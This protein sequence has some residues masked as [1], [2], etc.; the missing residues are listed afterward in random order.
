MGFT[1][2]DF[3]LK[4]AIAFSAIAFEIGQG[5]L[6]AAD[7]HDRENR[8]R[9]GHPPAPDIH[10]RQAVSLAARSQSAISSAVFALP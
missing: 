1:G 5:F 8:Q 7:A 6:A 2:P 10:E 4:T 9:I 3:D